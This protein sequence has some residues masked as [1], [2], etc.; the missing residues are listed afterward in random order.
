MD[1]QLSKNL[2]EIISYSKEE[3]MRL[4]SYTI[5]TDHLILG[6]IRHQDNSAFEMLL[7]FET[8][9][10]ALKIKIE[11]K[12]KVGNIIPFEQSDK[13]NISKGA[14]S[15]LRVMYLEAH[16]LKD[17]QPSP[18]HLLLAI[19]RGDEGVSIPLFKEVGITYDSV[20]NILKGKE[21]PRPANSATYD[22]ESDTSSRPSENESSIKNVKPGKLNSDTPVIDSFGFDLTGAALSGKL[23]PVVGRDREIERLAQILGRRKKNNPVI[24]GEPGV[25]KSAIAEGLA[26]RIAQ[27]KV[28]KVLM[29]KRVVSLDIGSIVAGTKYRGQFEERMKAIINELRKNSNIILFIDELHTLVGAGGASGSLDAANMLKPALARGEIQ[30]IGATTLD[31]YRE[32]IEKDGALERRFQKI[33]VEPTS[34]DETLNILQSI[35]ER[36]EKHHNVSYTNEALIAC[37]RLSQRYIT[38][39]CLPDKAIDALDEAG[40]RVHLKHLK[41]PDYI[42]KIENEI[43]PLRR[44]KH[45]AITNSEFEK[46]AELRDLQEQKLKNLEEAQQRWNNELNLHPQVVDENDVAE[47]LSMIT[48]VPVHR[49]AESEGDRLSNMASVIKKRIIGQDEAVE[50]VVRA[51]QRNRAGLKDPNKPIGTFIFLGPTGVGKTQLAKTLTEYLFD[52]VDNLIRIDMSE[53]GE[54][55]TLSR[56]IGAPP[57]YV[58]YEEGGQL[59]EKVR[60]KPY[61]VILLDEIEKAHPDIFNILLQVLDEGRLTDSNGRRIDFRNTLLIMTSNIGSREVKEYGSGLGF[62]TVTKRNISDNTRNIIEKALKKTF[63]PEFLNRL[64]DQILFNTLS[65]EDI[66]KIIDIELNDLFKRIEMAGYSLVITDEAKEFVAGEGYD[67]Q[68]GARPL[69]RAIQKYIEDPLAEAIVAGTFK[70]GDKISIDLDKEQ[71]SESG[72]PDKLKVTLVS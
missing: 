67:P 7:R 4:G 17:S 22:D 11:E 71:V 12:L 43:E 53:Y 21:S 14:E 31:E 48:S 68:L 46:A 54:K 9:H 55:F 15:S 10:K 57:G 40:S 62:S 28:S 61:S 24:I 63:T 16:S 23:D 56:L 37:I 50:K 30:C 58:G 64:D 44:E 66:C 38:D 5:G 65:R 2:N 33:M 34:Y 39:R 19:L 20:R 42:I 32:Y 8:D 41:V 25:G 27:K 13:I 36:Y 45:A 69:K 29:N 59:S 72:T 6:I 47:V 49:L 51:I 18:V 3:A 35:K 26:I 60:R 70:N 1:L 52:T